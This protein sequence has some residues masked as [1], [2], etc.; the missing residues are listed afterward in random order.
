M[1]LH[2]DFFVV[3]MYEGRVG[4]NF[5]NNVYNFLCKVCKK[6]TYSHPCDTFLA[7]LYKIL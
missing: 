3:T 7:H 6:I 1:L 2:N 5:V 4:D